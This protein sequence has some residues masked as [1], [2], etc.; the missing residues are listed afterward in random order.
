MACGLLSAGL[1][2]SCTNKL[3]GG[4]SPNVWIANKDDID[5]WT[6]DGTNSL[7][8]DSITMK[9]TKAFYLFEGKLKSTE[10]AARTVKGS[11]DNTWE[12][13]VK[14]RAFD[15]SPATLKAVAA[16]KDSQVVI[17]VQNNT[18][19]TAGNSKYDIYGLEGGLFCE[20]AERLPQNADD[21]GAWNITYK[22]QEYA[23]EANPPYRLFDTDEATT[24]AIIAALV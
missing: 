21:A 23:R 20:L 10:P 5:T 19:G 24:D 17:I 12:H 11:Y 8:V 9:A 16:M 14:I 2:L 18:K 13:E 22:T 3:V 6:Y 15:I 1:T 4:V 7:I